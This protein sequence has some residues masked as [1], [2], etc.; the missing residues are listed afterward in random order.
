MASTKSFITALLSV[1]T[2]SSMILEARQLLQTTTQ[3]NL[4]GIPSFP[5]PTTLPPLPSIPTFPQASLPPLP[6]TDSSLPKLTM[7]PLPSFPTTI[8]SLN[9]PPLPAITSL[10]NIPTSI[11]TTF[12]S[13]PFLSPLPSTSSP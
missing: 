3:P 4:P 11:P 7:P 12:S 13:I 1:V 2:M 9:I 5:K 10:P 8:P 6:T